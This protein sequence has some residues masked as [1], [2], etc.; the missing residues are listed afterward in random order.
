MIKVMIVEDDKGIQEAM[1]L[2]LS[3]NDCDVTTSEDGRELLKMSELELPEV[4]LLDIWMPIIDG[5][6]LCKALKTNQATKDIPVIFVSASRDLA[7][8]AKDA[9]ADGYLEKP[10]EMQELLDKVKGFGGQKY[11]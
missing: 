3:M 7:K 2:M 4:I 8:I 6:E 9:G 1:E 5:R 10:F 11:V